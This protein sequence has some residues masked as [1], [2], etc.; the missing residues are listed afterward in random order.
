LTA[1]ALTVS[2]QES[3][4]EPG[5]VTPQAA[6]RRA[7]AV[8]G[9][10]EWS[11]ARMFPERAVWLDLDDN[12]RALAL[13]QPELITPARGALIVLADEGQTAAEGLA[14]GLLDTLAERGVAVM[15]LGLR[16]PPESVVRRRQLLLVPAPSESMP[17]G[18][19]PQSSSVM[20]DVAEED[21]PEEVMSDYRNSVRELLDAAA[22][23]LERRGYQQPAVAGIGWSAD[24]VTAWAL[25]QGA[26]SGVIWL[27][28]RFSAERQSDLPG[29]LSADRPWRVLDLH[30]MDDTSR[31]PAVA[32]G[33]A[34]GREQVSGYRRQPVAL[35]N[36]PERADAERVASRIQAWLNR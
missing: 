29:V 4:P 34:L 7:T 23:D 36:P 35:S 27:A 11:L 25:G 16:T 9:L 32:R 21:A 1:L 8:T 2:A 15:T 31:H 17:P 10:G 30:A 24:Y 28:P 3:E 13:F 6:E 26:L 5:Q 22:R 12:S 20:I 33:A 14:G 19:E 18:E